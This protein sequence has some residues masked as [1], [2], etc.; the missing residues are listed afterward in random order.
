MQ[1]GV[2]NTGL[3]R[4]AFNSTLPERTC[5]K[6]CRRYC[7][8]GFHCR[9][10]SECTAQYSTL[11]FRRVPVQKNIGVCRTVIKLFLQK[12]A[13]A[14]GYRRVLKGIQRYSNRECPFRMVL[15]YAEECHAIL[16]CALQEGAGAEGCQRVPYS[17]K[18]YSA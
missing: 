17:T 16:D 3:C 11:L 6:R 13:G 15:E 2:K 14:E 7:V 1:K 8:D 10:V 12:V 4:T 18:W 9:R 5:A